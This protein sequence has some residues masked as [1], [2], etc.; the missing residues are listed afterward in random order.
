MGGRVAY[1]VVQREEEN[2]MEHESLTHQEKPDTQQTV[3]HVQCGETPVQVRFQ[4]E[5]EPF[6]DIVRRYLQQRDMR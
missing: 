5:G 3:H 2:Q 4:P 6:Q 1:A